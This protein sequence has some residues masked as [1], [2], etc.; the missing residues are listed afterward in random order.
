MSIK[1]LSTDFEKVS[2]LAGLLTSKATGKEAS[3]SDYEALRQQ[4]LQNQ[5]LGNL[6]PSWLKTHRNL[7][8][9]WGFIQPKFGTYADR[10]RFIAEEF[11]NALTMLEFGHT[12]EVR[13][14]QKRSLPPALQPDGSIAPKKRKVLIVHGRDNESKQEV[15]RFLESLG[16]GTIILHE[17]PSS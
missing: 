2:Y 1:F 15:A 5:E 17:Q 13:T 12:V 11:N 6:L 10:R 16:I 9:F 4:L 7:D 8:S 14:L 3:D